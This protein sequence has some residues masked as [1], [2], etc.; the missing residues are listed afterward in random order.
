[1]KAIN[2]FFS[3]IIWFILIAL[4][5]AG[6]SVLALR[7]LSPPPVTTLPS[8]GSVPTPT[9]KPQATEAT[10]S[11]P[12]STLDPSNP[13]RAASPTDP[14]TP[15][16]VPLTPTTSSATPTPT[17][18]SETATSPNPAAMP[19]LALP[20]QV[21]LNAPKKLE[22]GAILSIYDNVDNN[23]S[24]DPI[25]YSPT[26]RKK[27]AGLSLIYVENGFQEVS[28]YFL[29]EKTGTYA[30][31]LSFPHN[32]SLDTNNLRLRIDGQ[33][34]SNVK[35]GNLILEKGWHQVDLFLYA[36]NNALVPGQIQVKWGLEGSNLKPLQVWRE[37]K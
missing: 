10:P 13:N 26:S 16:Q 1:M 29:A 23:S 33:P 9:P 21:V 5:V 36:P 27:T 35:G 34:L 15:A 12:A 8:S 18:T 37:V 14:P 2:S 7:Y 20:T 24:P 32:Y 30:F 31:V 11:T 6:A 3:N 22:K 4:S 28:G 19:A 25:N 17:N